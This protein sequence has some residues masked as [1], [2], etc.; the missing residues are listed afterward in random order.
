[1]MKKKNNEE[2]G[3]IV[4]ILTNPDIQKGFSLLALALLLAFSA[5]ISTVSE[6]VEE[7]GTISEDDDEADKLITGINY[8]SMRT[9][10]NATLEI[11]AD[12]EVD[13]EVKI[14]D[15][16]WKPLYNESNRYKIDLTELEGTPNHFSFNVLEGN[17]TYIYTIAYVSRPYGLLSIPAVFVLLL[18]M[19]YSFKGKGVIL[20][21]IKRKKMEQEHREK[22]KERKK[23]KG[24]GTTKEKSTDS[25]S[26]P[27]DKVIYSGDKKEKRGDADHVNFMGVPDESEDEEK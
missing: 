21:E 26:A 13:F 6:E 12:D 2:R 22:R 24:E 15:S 5:V 27:G 25:D 3:M 9:I 1:M 4:R 19:I 17:L 8:P 16:E 20:G 23:S 10:E 14:L 18:G 11:E 7:K